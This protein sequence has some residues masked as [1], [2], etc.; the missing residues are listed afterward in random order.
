MTRLVLL[1]GFL[2]AGK[3]TTLLRLADH[4]VGSGRQVGILTNDQGRELVDSEIFRAHGFAA[5]EVR[6]G[7]FCCRLDEFIAQ[8]E[9]LTSKLLPDFLLA[10]PVGSC[11][12]IVA[13]VLR[14]LLGR[15]FLNCDFAPYTVLVDP[16]RAREALGP[17]GKASLSEKITYIYRL[18]QMEAAAIAVNKIDQLEMGELG[19]ILALLRARFPG[20]QLLSY[21]ARTADGF[22]ALANWLLGEGGERLPISPPIDYQIYADGEAELAWFDGRFDVLAA[23]TVDMDEALATLGSL[24]QAQIRAAGAEIAHVKLFLKA[25][26]LAGALSIPRTDTQPAPTLRAMGRATALELIVNARVATQPVVLRALVEASL[27]SWAKALAA[28]V[29]PLATSAFRPG[30]PVP[31]QRVG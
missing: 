15:Q 24:L 16:V 12:D 2:G 8:A 26:A 20:Q 21:S 27:L 1:G 31:T 29:S 6:D 28:S 3:T 7:C 13:T 11:T 22:D 18:Q 10:E 14:P 4:I 5:G 9:A 19:N 17:K 30:R 25:G 23:V